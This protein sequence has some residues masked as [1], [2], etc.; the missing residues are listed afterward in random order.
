M[1]LVT[2]AMIVG[3]TL[4]IGLGVLAAHVQNTVIDHA[5]QMFALIGSSIPVFWMGLALL[6]VFSVQWGILPSPGRLDARASPS[7]FGIR[8][9]V[10]GVNFISD[11]LHDCFDPMSK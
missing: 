4:G 7:G 2:A 10:L 6:Y 8:T 3:A 1:E 5:A 11:G 9:I